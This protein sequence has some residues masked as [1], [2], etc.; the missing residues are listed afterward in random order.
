[1]P[2]KNFGVIN[3][4]YLYL[5]DLKPG[6]M[7]YIHNVGESMLKNRLFDLGIVDGTGIECV[8]VAPLG[9]PGAY[10]V[11]GA[12]IAIRRDDAR[13]IK[14]MPI[15]TENFEKVKLKNP[16]VPVRSNISGG[17]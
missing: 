7:A 4:Q 15:G 9:G 3:I 11:R 8:A 13:R 12:V 2:Y 10:L 17:L 16:A 1:M 6:E 14:I 5:S